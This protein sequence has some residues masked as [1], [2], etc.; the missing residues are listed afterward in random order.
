MA[1]FAVAMILTAASTPVCS[2]TGLGSTATSAV[3]PTT[4]ITGKVELVT[5]HNVA[6]TSTY[7]VKM[8]TYKASGDME[9]FISRFEQYCV[10][11]NV[12][13]TRKANLLLNA[14]NGSTFTLVKREL[15]DNE[16]SNYDTIKKHLGKR[17]NLL[18]DAGQKQLIFRQAR[19]E[20]GQKIEEFFTQLLGM[21]AKAFPGE[22]G[23]AVDRMILDQ[24]ICGCSHEKICFQ[25][26]EKAPA[27]SSDALSLA[28]AFQ[29]AI[30]YNDSLKENVLGCTMPI[31]E[32]RVAYRSRSNGRNRDYFLY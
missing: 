4:V 14:L 3:L 20:H 31:D 8:P 24:L 21:A 2:T 25:L 6:S 12:E 1:E 27:T 30:K 29:A 7:D 9:I 18:K 22:S 16:T 17:F 32:Y 19:R 10:T 5:H 11:Q 28:V 13:E 15:I 23:Q 26:I